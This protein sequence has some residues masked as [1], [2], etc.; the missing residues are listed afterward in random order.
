VVNGRYST[1]T[2]NNP[3][4]LR[5]NGGTQFNGYIG[6]KEGF[7]GNESIGYFAVFDTKTN[8]TRAGLKNLEGYFTRRKLKTIKSIINTYAPGGSTGQSQSNTNSYVNSVVNYMKKNWNAS[9]TDT[10]ILSFSG[11]LETNPNNIKMFKELNLAILKQ[12][13]K[14]TTDLIASINSFD[15]KNLA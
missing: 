2:D 12:E 3:F 4:N 7:R 15:T 9:V 6:K 5:P 10:T 14:L 8:G 1:F 11:A 13:G